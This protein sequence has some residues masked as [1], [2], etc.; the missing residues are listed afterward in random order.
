M[1]K[2]KTQKAKAE[3]PDKSSL[4]DKA[5]EFGEFFEQ[6]K[7]EIK[8]VV[9]PSRKEVTATSI[10]VLVLTII[11]AIFLGL[12]DLGLSKLVQTILS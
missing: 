1:A 2:E 9:W 7:V 4:A 3:T 12:V 5:K 11:L 10:A 6:S 8:K